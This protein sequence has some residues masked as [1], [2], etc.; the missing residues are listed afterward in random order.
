MPGRSSIISI[1]VVIAVLLAIPGFFIGLYG[2]IGFLSLKKIVA[3]G[4]GAFW[5]YGAVMGT[6]ELIRRKYDR[7]KWRQYA[8]RH[9]L[10]GTIAVAMGMIFCGATRQTMPGLAILPALSA[11]IQANDGH[12]RK[13][14]A[15]IHAAVLGAGLGLGIY[16]YNYRWAANWLE[17]FLERMP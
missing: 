9:L 15:W 11:V 2:V 8:D 3:G 13:Y 5:G 16:I 12:K 7:D 17:G 10:A 1:G 4:L 6:Y 14:R